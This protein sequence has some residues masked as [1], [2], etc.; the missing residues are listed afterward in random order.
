MKIGT[1]Q[2]K[3]RKSKDSLGIQKNLYS[4]E[5]ENLNDTVY[6]L[7]R[8][9]LL[10]LNQEQLNI[11]NRPMTPNIIIE[12]VVKSL[13]NKNA[14]GQIVLAVFYQIIKEELI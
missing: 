5:L 13:L 7:D 1:Q 10:K 12:G 9:H 4:T 8:H 11:L 3:L 6:F 2:K 14:Q